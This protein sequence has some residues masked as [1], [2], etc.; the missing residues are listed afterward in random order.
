[1]SNIEHLSYSSIS[2]YLLCPRA[3]FLHY[4]QKVQTPTATALVFGSAFHNTIEQYLTNVAQGNMAESPAELWGAKW[5]AQIEREPNVAWELET[6]EGLRDEGARLLASKPIAEGIQR[7]AANFDDPEKL[8]KRVNLQVPGVPVPIIGY[9]DVITADGIPGDFKTSAR[10]WTQDKADEQQQSLFYL[11]ALNQAGYPTPGWLFRHYVAVKT[12]RP[13][14]QVFEHRHNPAQLMW[15]FD[16][17]QHV[18]KGIEAGSFPCRCDSWKCSP[19]YCE[20]FS[21]CRGKYQ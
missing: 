13:Q 6:P 1:M 5:T 12:Q 3:W 21:M 16:T 4:I 8:E 9:I 18:W 17:I 11:A 7:V 19:K 10:A 2:S 14:W 20:H 15:L